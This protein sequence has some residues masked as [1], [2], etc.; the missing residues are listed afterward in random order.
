MLMQDVAKRLTTAA[1]GE[2][3]KKEWDNIGKFLRTVYSTAENDMKAVAKGIFN[4]DNNK[5]ALNDVAEMK[6]YAQAGDV[7]VSKQDASRLAAILAKINELLD[8]FLASLSD[9]PDEI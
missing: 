9:I 4:P 8:D 3:D 5:Q 6:K 2:I 1:E 7:S